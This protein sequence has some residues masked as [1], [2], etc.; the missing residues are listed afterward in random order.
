MKYNININQLALSEM[1]SDMDVADAAVLDYIIFICNSPHE[2]IDGQ[3][4]ID[5]DGE[6]WT[7]IDLTSLMNGMPLLRIRSR[8]AISTR[9]Q[10]IAENGFIYVFKKRVKGRPRLF[11]KLDRKVDSLFVKLD[12]GKS[13]STKLDG[14]VHET[15]Q[16]QKTDLANPSPEN[17]KPVHETGRIITNNVITDNLN[18]IF[19][20]FWDLYPIKKVKKPAR[21]IWLRKID[22]ALGELII[23]DVEK[24]KSD[25][26]WVEGYIPNATTYL[27]QERW[28][29][30]I[31]IHS[32]RANLDGSQLR[33]VGKYE[34][35]GTKL[36]I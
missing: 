32:T 24:R 13:L 23:Q 12:R 31:I 5:K 22:P 19:D 9:I 27:N 20:R 16:G 15:G 10:K 33:K 35:V 28:N 1:S 17:Q 6:V 4:Y 25:R 34:N 36:K 18:E 29:D 7:W 14:P 8:T 26:Q 2:K 3:R 11:V 30:E 21:D